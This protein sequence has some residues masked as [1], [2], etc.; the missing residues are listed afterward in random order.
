MALLV[1]ALLS[2]AAVTAAAAASAH[3]VTVWPHLNSTAPLMPL[4]RRI[5]WLHMPKSGTSFGTSLAHLANASLPSDAA[6]VGCVPGIKC[7]QVSDVC[8]PS[9]RSNNL[10]KLLYPTP[11]PPT[12]TPTPNLTVHSPLSL[13]PMVPWHVLDQAVDQLWQS[14]CALGQVWLE[15]RLCRPHILDVPQAKQPR[16]TLNAPSWHTMVAV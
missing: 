15:P 3:N 16:S 13:R 12:P 1:L 5:G 2:S 9:L 14:R 8:Q 10:I 11:T 6:I 4:Y 7:Q